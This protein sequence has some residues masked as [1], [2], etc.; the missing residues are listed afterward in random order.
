MLLTCF[1]AVLLWIGFGPGERTF[2]SSIGIMGL[3]SHGLGNQTTGRVLF[4]TA[5]VLIGVWAA[6]AWIA[7]VRG[8]M[9]S[10]SKEPEA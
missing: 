6:V 8:V 3:A 2:S 10:F 4:G 5:G 7:L 1:A 9:A